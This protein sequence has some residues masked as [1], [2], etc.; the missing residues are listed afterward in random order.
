MWLAILSSQKK[1]QPNCKGGFH[2]YWE[3]K[4]YYLTQFYSLRSSLV[5][6]PFASLHKNEVSHEG[7][8]IRISQI[9]SFLRIWSH[10][11]KKSLMG[12]FIFCAVRECQRRLHEVIGVAYKTYIFI[13]YIRGF[14]KSTSTL[15]LLKK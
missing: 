13:F 8:R 7:F 10:L 14:T 6:S 4:Q 1:F 11:L 2:K 5:V 12:N 9:H 3:K 15:A